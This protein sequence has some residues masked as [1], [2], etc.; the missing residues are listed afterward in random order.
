AIRFGLLAI[1]NLGAGFISFLIQEREANGP[2]FSYYSFCKRVY[3][4]EFN[5]RS[6]ENLIKSGA[7]D[8][9]GHNRR[10]MLLMIDDILASLES[11]KKSKVEGQI[12]FFDLSVDLAKA[13]EPPVPDVT[14]MPERERLQLEK[15]TTG[16]Y[17]S[18]HP[19]TEY[20]SLSKKLNSAKTSSLMASDLNDPESPYHD[21]DKIRILCLLST[22][23]KKITKND[24]TMAFLTI[25]DTAGSIEVLVFPKK[26]EQYADLLVEDHVVLLTGKLSLR[27]DE[28]PKLLLEEVASVD[29][30]KEDEDAIQNYKLPPMEFKP[31]Q[32]S[33]FDG[34][35]ASV[36]SA[37][38]SDDEFDA[39]S[40]ADLA[41][42][43][44]PADEAPLPPAPVVSAPRPAMRALPKNELL[45][46]NIAVTQ[47]NSKKGIF[48]R[49]ASRNG[50]AV[51]RAKSMCSIFDEGMIPVVFF[52]ADE[53][54]YDF[55][56]GIRTEWNDALACGLAGLLGEKNVAVRL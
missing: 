14:E 2:F 32:R 47:N 55:E 28:M 1:K 9:F 19:M 21:G 18:G 10:Q 24:T 40:A 34:S 51:K 43:P 52:Y 13:S 17:M 29:G 33:S 56:S 30:M 26:Y 16:M 3:C 41:S 7:C 35:D 23:R 22:V 53:K 36:P 49:V 27:D 54:V 45:K 11:D 8:C 5:R 12:G 38:M 6:L 39:I 48:V 50:E 46:P 15:E 20:A 31:L 4:K 44:L 37:S 25:E 42:I